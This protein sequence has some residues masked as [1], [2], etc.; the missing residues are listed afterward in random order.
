MEVTMEL[1]L[2]DIFRIIWARIWIIVLITIVAMLASG[3]I[4]YFYLDKIYESSTTLIVNKQ[5]DDNEKETQYTYN[6]ILLSQK[7]VST[8][9]EIAKSSYVLERVI[10]E[11]NLDLSPDE[12]KKM[13]AVSAVGDTQIIRITVS[14]VFPAR[15]TVIAE[16]MAELLPI[17]V[18][19]LEMPDNVKVVD[20]AKV[21]SSPVKPRPLMNIAI[22]GVLG[23]M[24]GLG[25]IFLIEY[26]DN[27]IK[28]PDDV[29]KYLGLPVLGSIPNFE[30]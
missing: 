5:K 6:D 28:T 15:A 19:E 30:D 9:T 7:L 20:K 14:D 23:I 22:A 27:T 13:I 12:L 8:Y 21:P 3:I 4:S 26:L 1:E 10:K 29:Q 11:L 25:I 16:K 17:R 18:S 24:V 2:R